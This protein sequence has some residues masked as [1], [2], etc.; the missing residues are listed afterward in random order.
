[1]HNQL[2][3]TLF[4][5]PEVRL[6]GE[7]ITGFRSGKAQALLYYLAVTG[8]P[9]A[10]SML[11]GLLWGD[12]PEAAARVS[13]SKCLSNLYDLVGDAVLIERQNAAFNY[14]HSYF[15]DSE[16]LAATIGLSPTPETISTLQSS[17]AL[18]RGDF[19]EGFYVRDAP[20]FEQWLL[21]QRAHYREAVVN[22]LYVLASYMD[23]QGDLPGAIVLT[24]RLLVLEP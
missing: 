10:R 20:D 17:L 1:M 2:E 11:A 4:G 14:N 22:A 13:L 16:R 9:H 21:L 24:R 3:F 5:S 12:Q 15:L 6:N 7:R 8:R 18:Y 23:R 19:L